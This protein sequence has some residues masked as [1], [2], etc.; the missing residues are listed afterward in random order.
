MFMKKFL[1]LSL[2]C[3]LLVLL[4]AVPSESK[5]HTFKIT[6]EQAYNGWWESTI[7]PVLTID[8][9]D[10]VIFNTVMLFEGKLRPGM[11][12]PELLKLRDDIVASGNGVYAFTGPFFI[13]DAEPGDVLEVRIKR[14]VPTDHGVAYIYPDERKAGGLPDGSGSF[15]DGWFGSFYFSEDRKSFEFKPG[16][17]I[18]LSP[19]LGTM[20]VSPKPGERRPPA[21]PD[22]FAGNMD[23]KELV[24]GTTLYLPINVPGA[25][26][27]AADAHAVQADGEVCI[28][29]METYMEEVEAEFIVRK[30][31]KL[32]LPIAETPTHWITMGFH[33]DLGEAMRI[34]LREAIHFLATTKDMSREEAFALCSMAVDFR[35]TQ[36][37][38]GNKG[39]HGMIPKSIFTK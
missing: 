34:A 36:I 8:N 39:I 23:N 32:N 10:T 13:N 12:I 16:V 37:V 28:T 27:M 30:D 9:G 19:F 1:L 14:I 5:V 17:T 6:P 24:A 11:T 25:L 29:G 18:P 2:L 15:K 4:I 35:V 22:Y 3:M 26:F 20:G 38:D 7:P 31:M 33:E 21:V